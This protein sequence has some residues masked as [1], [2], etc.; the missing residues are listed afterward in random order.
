MMS[1]PATH[2]S[3]TTCST[4]TSSN[5]CVGMNTYLDNI[6]CGRSTTLDCGRLLESC[7]RWSWMCAWQ[8]RSS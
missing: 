3:T 2:T 7:C 4:E 6:D 8:A 1:A 5:F